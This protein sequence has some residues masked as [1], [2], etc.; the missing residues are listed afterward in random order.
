MTQQKKIKTVT[1]TEQATRD[2]WPVL[3]IL[4]NM[5][6]TSRV[7]LETTR[8][9]GTACTGF[10]L[11][12]TARSGANSFICLNTEKLARS[13]GCV[14]ISLESK[15]GVFEGARNPAPHVASMLARPQPTR[16]SPL[17]L[18]LRAM[19]AHRMS[20]LDAIAAE[21][22]CTTGFVHRCLACVRARGG[23]F[24]HRLHARI[25]FFLVSFDPS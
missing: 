2:H 14:S 19:I 1:W 16:F 20:D 23:H 9:A 22:A 5:A 10:V 18:E 21:K 12:V 15:Q 24:E 4:A 3:F 7:L 6:R 8:L 11:L 25:F 17:A 13:T